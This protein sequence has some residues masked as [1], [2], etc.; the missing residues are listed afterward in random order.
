MRPENLQEVIRAAPFRPF[1][2]ML[3]DGTRLHVPHPEWVFLTPGG[4]TV[5]WADVADHVK[6]LDVALLL[7]VELDQPVPAGTIVP[8]P[9]GGEGP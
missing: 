1:A 5:V 3:A 4:R 2:L 7:G 6:L 9:D 8:E